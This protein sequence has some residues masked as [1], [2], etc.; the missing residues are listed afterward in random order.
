MLCSLRHMIEHQV[1]KTEKFGNG[2]VSWQMSGHVLINVAGGGAF[3]RESITVALADVTKAFH[4]LTAHPH[5]FKKTGFTSTRIA[6]CNDP[7]ELRSLLTHCEDRSKH[8][9]VCG[10]RP[11]HAKI[12][13]AHP[14]GGTLRNAMSHAPLTRKR[15]RQTPSHPTRPSYLRMTHPHKARA[16]VAVNGEM[17]WTHGELTK[18]SLK[19]IE[20]PNESS[21]A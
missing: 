11:S 1:W 10:M 14:Q 20:A 18:T 6:P 9:L 17:T 21:T 5:Y 12:N 16:M 3:D 2:E 13:Q 4:W 19:P 7:H 8:R 15:E